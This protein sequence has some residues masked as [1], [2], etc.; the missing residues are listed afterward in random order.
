[1]VEQRVSSGTSQLHTVPLKSQHLV[2]E[3]KCF[4]AA[5]QG[6]G[7]QTEKERDGKKERRKGMRE[8]GEKKGKCINYS[9]ATFKEIP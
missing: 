4:T 2:M 5:A 3:V 1:M 7:I 6:Q 9:N 8:G